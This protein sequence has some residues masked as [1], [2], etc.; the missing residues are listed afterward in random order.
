M[1]SQRRAIRLRDAANIPSTAVMVQFVI[2][3]RSRMRRHC[4]TVKNSISSSITFG[5]FTAANRI[6]G[7][8]LVE[9][10]DYVNTHP[11][12]IGASSVFWIKA[13]CPPMKTVPIRDVF[14]WRRCEHDHVLIVT[15]PQ[16][17]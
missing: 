14:L 1:L 13:L 12:K 9:D 11:P 8:F 2:R 6:L 3:A 15:V 16:S 5:R 10:A 4:S 7:A 17:L